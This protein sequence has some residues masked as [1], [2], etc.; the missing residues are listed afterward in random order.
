MVRR[1]FR[2]SVAREEILVIFEKLGERCA[3]HAGQLDFGLLRSSARARA[4]G[5]VLLAAARGLD[6]LIDR[7]IAVR[8]QK[9]TTKGDRALIDDFALLVGLELAIAAAG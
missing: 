1:P 4:F 8:R 5:D 9:T 6:H 2:E 3:R 7:A